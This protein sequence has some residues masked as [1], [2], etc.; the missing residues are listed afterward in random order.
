MAGSSTLQ[1]HG[2]IFEYRNQSA[3][4]VNSDS[5]TKMNDYQPRLG[6][7]RGSGPFNPRPSGPLYNIKSNKLQYFAF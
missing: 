2:G 7:V 6:S 4:M 3:A 1:S 5:V